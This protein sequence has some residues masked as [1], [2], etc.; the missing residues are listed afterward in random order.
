VSLARPV[1]WAS[2][3]RHKYNARKVTIDALT[4]DSQA[5]ARRYSQLRILERLGDIQALARQVVF[6]LVVNG[7]SVGKYIA[8]FQYCTR[9]G[10]L[11]VED[12]KGVATPVYRLKKRIVEAQYGLRI[13]EVA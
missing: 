12:C 9:D 7:V 1:R 8:D 4:F 3:R 5:E 10:E 2:A 11:V 13:T 6:P